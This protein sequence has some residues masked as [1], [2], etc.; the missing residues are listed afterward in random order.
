MKMTPNTH[1][2]DGF[3]AFEDVYAKACELLGR[4]PKAQMVREFAENFHAKSLT[5]LQ[6][7]EFD[8]TDAEF[9]SAYFKI[10]HMLEEDGIDF[11]WLDWQQGNISKKPGVDPLWVLNHFHYWDSASHDRRPIT[12]SRFGGPGSQRYPIGFSGVSDVG[13]ATPFLPNPPQ[14]AVSSWDSLEF[15][16]EFTA[17]A[18]NIGYGWWSHDIGGHWGGTKVGHAWTAGSL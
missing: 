6:P 10:H 8:C 3:R 12:F 1:P 13:K 5:T 7:I 11:W 16:P 17:T 18:A 4:D 15:Q 9:M 2:A 14:D